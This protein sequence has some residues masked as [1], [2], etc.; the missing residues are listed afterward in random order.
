VV[1]W[2]W[3]NR[4]VLAVTRFVRLFIRWVLVWLDYLVRH[5]ARHLQVSQRMVGWLIRPRNPN[6]LFVS[7]LE[8]SHTAPE[9]A[10]AGIPD[11]TEGE[12]KHTALL[13]A[14]QEN[15]LAQPGA[16]LETSAISLW[17]GTQQATPQDSAP[18][19]AAANRRFAYL[20]VLATQLK[21]L[22]SAD[23]QELDALIQ[24]LA[25]KWLDVD[26]TFE[27]LP[28]R[29]R[30]DVGRTMRYNIPRYAGK[31]LNFQWATKERPVPQLAKPARIL[32]IGD[33]SHSMVQYVSII[34]YFFHKLNFKFFIDSYI[35][36]EKATHS[37]PFLNGLGTFDEKVQRL[38][39]GAKSWNAGT[40]FGSALEE[41][42]RNATVDENTY[43]IIATD[44]K[45]SLQADESTKI[46]RNMNALRAR[47][48]QVIFLT[49]SADF[50][51]G[52]SGKSSP[53][54]LGSFKYGFTE[55]PIFSMGPPLWYGTLAGYADRLYLIRTVQDLLDMTEDLILSSRQHH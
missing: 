38:I 12:D 36:S 20:D 6:N 8:A 1:R 16:P 34:L 3:Q 27:Q 54:K 5:L 4:L 24:R 44:G 47:A 46:E 45:V 40:R 48:R 11:I 15:A 29:N 39:A 37:S 41:I 51:D 25:R 17:R 53:E 2:V 50:T 52:A 21:R 30:L 22:S 13:W 43:V 14:A 7:G 31:I 42:A 32:V 55:I 49:P 23:I 18:G 10:L 9:T 28:R 35:F 26:E 19:A 33:V